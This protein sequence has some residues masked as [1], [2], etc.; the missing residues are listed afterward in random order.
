MSAAVWGQ[1]SRDSYH[2][3]WVGAGV[4]WIAAY[5]GHHRWWHQPHS[6]PRDP[7]HHHPDSRSISPSPPRTES[8]SPSQ[9]TSHR[10]KERLSWGLPRGQSL[11]NRP[12]R[13]ENCLHRTW[14]WTLQWSM[15]V[16]RKTPPTAPLLRV[17]SCRALRTLLRWT[18]TQTCL[19]YFRLHL[20]FL[21]TQKC[22]DFPSTLPLLPPPIIPATSAPKPQLP[23]SPSAHP[24]P[25][26]CA[27]GSL[28]L[29]SQLHRLHRHPSAHQLHHPST[30]S[31]LRRHQSA[32]W[33]HQPF[34]HHG[35]SLQ[36]L[37]RGPPSGL[38]PG[39][40]LASPAQSQNCLCPGSSLHLICPGSYCFLPGSFLHRHHPGLCGSSSSR[41][42]VL[43]Q[44]LHLYYL[45]ANPSLS[46]FSIPRTLICPPPKSPSVPPFFLCGA[47]SRLPGGW[48]SVTPQ[49]WFHSPCALWP[50]FCLSLIV[51]LCSGVSS[52]YPHLRSPY[53]VSCIQF[54]VSLF[55]FVYVWVCLVPFYDGLPLC[56]LLKTVYLY[57]SSSFVHSCTTPWQL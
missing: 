45:P 16:L 26:L 29:G 37:H 40:R 55:G 38:W 41:V 19:F 39:S 20:N 5:C 34:F 36:R 48:R 6:W 31:S 11:I 7:A 28:Y 33:S 15:R 2:L 10:K 35:S 22:L 27:V 18:H 1:S 50:S 54:C 3:R 47:R 42:Y 46:P 21:A 53:T 32:P 25:S 24:Q 9:P 44:S 14:R 13:C 23:G 51:S 30:R 49:D 43:R 57:S 56:G 52:C 17:S 8:Q 12:T 4:L